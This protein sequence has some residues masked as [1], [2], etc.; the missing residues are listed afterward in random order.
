MDFQFDLPKDA[1]R[2]WDLDVPIVDGKRSTDV[3][4]TDGIGE[5]FIYNEL[6][7]RLKNASPDDT[8]N[9]HLNTPGGHVDSAFMIIDAIKQSAATTVACLS[10]TVA[11]AGT[12]LALACDNI[13]SADHIGFMIHNYSAGMVGKGN[14]LK[15]RQKFTDESL[16]AAFKEFYKHFLTDKEMKEVIDGQ[17]YWLSKDEVLRR[18]QRREDKRSETPV[19]ASLDNDT[20]KPRKRGRPR[21]A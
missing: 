14:E 9:I 1:T 8:F 13:H 16:E 19:T 2:V 4:L 7:Y 20:P 3:Y 17:D 12:M 21:K 15:A 11:S 5:P 6:C 18:W 10:G